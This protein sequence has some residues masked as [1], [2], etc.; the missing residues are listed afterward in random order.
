M[1]RIEVELKFESN[2]SALHSMAWSALIM[3]AAWIKARLG[4]RPSHEQSK[5]ISLLGSRVGVA[6][7]ADQMRPGRRFRPRLNTKEQEIIWSGV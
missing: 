4:K 1:L 2:N 6:S 3:I 5:W 7:L